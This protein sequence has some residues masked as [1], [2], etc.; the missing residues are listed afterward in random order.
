MNDAQLQ[1]PRHLC[2]CGADFANED[3]LSLH[4]GET[5]HPLP[6][7]SADTASARSTAPLTCPRCLAIEAHEGGDPLSAHSLGAGCRLVAA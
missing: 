1:T 3:A 2:S 5:D 6:D 4:R 7:A